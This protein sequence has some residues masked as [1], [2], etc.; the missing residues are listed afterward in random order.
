MN[1]STKYPRGTNIFSADSIAVLEENID[2]PRTESEIRQ[3]S[4]HEEYLYGQRI[5]SLKPIGPDAS[6][7]QKP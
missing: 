4:D 3:F 6:R 5:I 1:Q 2:K 7:N